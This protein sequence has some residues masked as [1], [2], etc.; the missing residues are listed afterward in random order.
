[1]G[2]PI[3]FP[4]GGIRLT[5]SVAVLVGSGDPNLSTQK[6]VAGAGVGS[7]FL[8]TDAPTSVTCLYVCVTAGIKRTPTIN[9]VNAVWTAK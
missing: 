2:T 6:D 4:G 3:G 9:P 1:M 7:L 5:K 8:R